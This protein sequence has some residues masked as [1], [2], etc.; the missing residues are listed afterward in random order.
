MKHWLSALHATVSSVAFR[1]TRLTNIVRCRQAGVDEKN[2]RQ[3]LEVEPVSSVRPRTRGYRQPQIAYC[4][5][6]A[7][8]S[9]PGSSYPI[10]PGPKYMACRVATAITRAIPITSPAARNANRPLL[11][12]RRSTACPLQRGTRQLSFH[13]QSSEE[14]GYTVTA[15]KNG[16]H[17]DSSRNTCAR[18]KIAALTKIRSQ[19]QSLP[20]QPLPRV[21]SCPLCNDER[22]LQVNHVNVICVIIYNI[23]RSAS[24]QQ[25]K[26]RHHLPISS[27]SIT[28]HMNRE[29]RKAAEIGLP[30]Y[31]AKKW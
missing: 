6:R 29:A 20:Q 24:R 30:F 7:C 4:V 21:S 8:E 16:I 12:S 25:K 31:R 17:R 28:C 9:T 13:L 3:S 22:L 18:S 19:D 26:D 10:L 27:E 1:A 5:S 23:P 14:S 15:I 2:M 11:N